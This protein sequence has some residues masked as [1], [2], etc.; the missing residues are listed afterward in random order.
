MRRVLILLMLLP[1]LLF[2]GDITALYEEL[3]LRHPDFFNAV[4]RQEAGRIVASLEAESA[5]Y[6]R[7]EYWYAL[8]KVAAIAHDSHTQVAL[9][10]NVITSIHFLPIGFDLFEEGLAIVWA[11]AGYEELL[12]QTVDTI[13]GLDFD[14]ILALAG[15]MIGNDNEVHLT[16]SLLDNHLVFHEFYETIGLVEEGEDITIALCDGRLVDIP[17]LSFDEWAAMER[18]ILQEAIPPTLNP[19][20]PYSAML[21]DDP[22]ALLVNYHSCV[23]WPAMPMADF[24]LRVEDLVRQ[25]GFTKVIIDLRYN[26][27]GDSSVIDPLVDALERIQDERGLEV[28]VLIGE[29]SFSSAILNALT[30]C[31][32]LGA[33]LVGRPTGGNVSHF[34]ELDSFVL[35]DTGLTCWYSTKWFDNGGKGP[36]MPDIYAP[37]HI[38]DYRTGRDGALVQLGVVQ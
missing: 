17:A 13:C 31:E 27:G 19:A 15:D 21:L 10:A 24:A 32:R 37:R 34:G 16:Q 5:A 29:D 20:S 11:G 38:E 18:K 2:A 7:V 33:I 35:P 36:L 9:D 22:E 14:G 8:E 26:A 3:T 23:D 4:S 6:D 1:G 28:Y 30:L 12:G 25:E